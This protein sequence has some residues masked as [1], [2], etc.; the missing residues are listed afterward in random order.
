VDATTL[1]V[2]DQSIPDTDSILA[3]AGLSA[4]ELVDLRTVGAIA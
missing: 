2:R 3:D 1:Q 4:A